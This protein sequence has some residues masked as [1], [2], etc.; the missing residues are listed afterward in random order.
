MKTVIAVARGAAR[1]CFRIVDRPT[2]APGPGDLLVRVHA[3]GV[4]PSDFKV[5]S[6]AQ[7][8][9]PAPEVIPH[10]DGAGVI[11]AVGEGVATDRIGQ[12]VWLF[13]VNRSEDGQ[14]QGS[15]GTAAERIVVA[16]RYAAPLPDGVSFEA[17]AC[18]GIPAMTAHRALTADGPVAGQWIMVTGGAGAVGQSAVSLAKFLGARVIA[19]VSGPEKAAV[20]M[21]AGADAAIDYRREDVAE[22]A[23]RIT[24]GARVDRIVDVALSDYLEAA[25]RFLK[26]GGVIATYGTNDATPPLPYRAL[27][28]GNVVIRFVFVYTMDDAHRADAIRDINAALAEGRLKPVIHRTFPLDAIAQAHEAMEA[29]GFSGNIVLTA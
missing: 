6:G 17:G 10:S 28:L 25:P 4:N 3:S 21:A 29:G 20:A 19:T 11:E 1:D 24:G 15:R 8:P 23:L 7:G 16:A 14:A 13:N 22:A 18:L 9:Q 5:R 2:P 12:R 26:Q 27:L